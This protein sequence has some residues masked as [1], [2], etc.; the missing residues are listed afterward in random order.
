MN[1]VTSDSLSLLGDAL[2]RLAAAPVLLVATDY[3]GTLAGLVDDPSDAVAHPE[4]IAALRSLARADDTYGAVISGRSLDDLRS[5]ASMDGSIRMVGSHGSEFDVGFASELD[6]DRSDLRTKLIASAHQVSAEIGGRVEEKPAG[7]AFHLRGA[8]PDV[9]HRA[10]RALTDGPGTWDGIFTRQGH[11]V[12][13]LTVTAT[14]KGDGGGR[15]RGGGRC[16]AH[17]TTSPLA[18]SASRC[19]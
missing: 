10:E 19:A 9:A 4:S 3:D 18:A 16:L 15:R 12:V 7:L 5:V 13:E 17:G 6:P 11:D 8:D 14:N 1:T 2:R